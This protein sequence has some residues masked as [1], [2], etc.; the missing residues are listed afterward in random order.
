MDLKISI[1]EKIKE[2]YQNKT[3]LYSMIERNLKGKYR[4]SYLGFAWHFITPFIMVLLFYIV[5][6]SIRIN[7]VEFYWIYLCVGMLPFSFFQTNLTNGVS[8]IIS[9]SG[10]INKMYFPR[11]IIVLSQ[12]ISAL[13]PFI[14]SYTIV[15][16]AMILVGFSISPVIFLLPIMFILSFLFALGYTLILSTV[17]VFVRDVQY[18]IQAISRIMFWTTPIFYLVNNIDGILSTIIWCN[19]YTYFIESFHDIIYYG[20]LPNASVF[21]MCLI[22]TFGTLTIGIFIFNKYQNKFAEKL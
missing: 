12:I 10:M 6:T 7:P 8:C 16:I 1:V 17:T 14:I 13:I 15:I 9:N 5:F 20:T 11:I 4:N 22:L 21:I 2:V 3:I 18:F 19:P